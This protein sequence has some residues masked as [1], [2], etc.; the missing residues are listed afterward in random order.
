MC[1][2]ND[3]RKYVTFIKIDIDFFFDIMKINHDILLITSFSISPVGIVQI[4]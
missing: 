4:L 1:V 3:E 2:C